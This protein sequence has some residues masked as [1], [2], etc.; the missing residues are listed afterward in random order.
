[1]AP[2]GHIAFV[3]GSYVAIAPG[4]MPMGFSSPRAMG[5]PTAMPSTMPYPRAGMPVA[6]CPTPAEVASHKDQCLKGIAE[7]MKQSQAQLETQ[8]AHCAEA[9]K[10]QAEKHRQA[11]LLQVEQLF[12]QQEAALEQQYND[13]LLQMQQ[14]AQQQRHDLEKQAI[15]LTAR[16][17]QEV[18]EHETM[19]RQLQLRTEHEAVQKKFAND[20]A[21]SAHKFAA[22]MSR[23]QPMPQAFP[24]SAAPPGSVVLG[25]FPTALSFVPPVAGSATAPS[26]RPMVA[27]MPQHRGALTPMAGS[28]IGSPRGVSFNAMVPQQGRTNGFI[29]PSG[30]M[31]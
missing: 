27:M 19:S 1:M 22:E 16:Y 23:L 26:G 24:V 3:P 7:S 29:S 31:R 15:A 20:N 12:K 30:R 13:R 18:V 28:M 17:H 8:R 5:V 10:Q 25:G 9:L 4:G 2:G 14:A 6:A 11:A 21:T